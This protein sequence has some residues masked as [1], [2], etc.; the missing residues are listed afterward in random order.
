MFAVLSPAK[1]LNEPPAASSLPHSTPF[2]LEDTVELMK[3]TRMLS[4]DDLK[5]LMNISDKLADLNWQRFNAFGLPF[6]PNNSR[7]S[8]LCFN[9]DTYLGLDASTLSEDNLAYSQEHLGILSGLYG[10]LRPL[11]LSQP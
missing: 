7:Q 4:R 8:V 5:S 6:T 10:I 2:L 3:T 1:R 11:D 9:G